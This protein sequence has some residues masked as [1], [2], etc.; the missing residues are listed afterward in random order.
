MMGKETEKKKYLRQSRELSV[1]KHV[2]RKEASTG[3]QS[4][5]MV[6]TAAGVK[7]I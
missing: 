6:P 4:K 7:G 2:T 3:R 1:L 5:Q